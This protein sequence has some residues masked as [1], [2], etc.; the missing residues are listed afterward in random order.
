MKVLYGKGISVVDL[1][2]RFGGL[3]VKSQILQAEEMIQKTEAKQGEIVLTDLVAEDELIEQKNQRNQILQLGKDLRMLPQKDTL[4]VLQ[5]NKRLQEILI[6]TQ[7]RINVQKQEQA[8][9]QEAQEGKIEVDPEI[10]IV[11]DLPAENVIDEEDV[12]EEDD[13]VRKT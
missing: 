10:P 8:G 3:L 13:P 6:E 7:A 5:K 4:G 12:K 2:K 11:V 1:V 9:L